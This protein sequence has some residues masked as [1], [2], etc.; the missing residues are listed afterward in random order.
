MMTPRLPAPAALIAVLMLAACVGGN[1]GLAPYDRVEILR[2]VPDAD[3]DS[4]TPAQ[5]MRLSEALHHG[6]GFDTAYV[7]RSILMD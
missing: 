4:L 2:Y 3:L 7:I 5:E 6:D 1:A